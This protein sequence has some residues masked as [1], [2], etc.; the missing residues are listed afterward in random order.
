MNTRSPALVPPV[1]VRPAIDGEQEGLDVPMIAPAF[2][3]TTCD[4]SGS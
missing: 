3:S 4:R 2:M 1:C